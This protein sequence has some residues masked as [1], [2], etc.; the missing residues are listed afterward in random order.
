MKAWVINK[1]SEVNEN[2]PPLALSEIPIPDP[3]PGEILVKVSVCGVCHTELDEIEGRTPPPVL[4]MIPGHQ[5][6]GIVSKTG[7][8]VKKW[9]PGDRVGVAWIYS[10]CGKCNYCQNGMENLC[11]EFKATGRDLPGGYAN[12]MIADE[13]YCYRIPPQM[14]DKKAAPLFCAGAIG[15]RSVNL[16]GLKNGMNLGLSGFG[17]SAHLVMKLVRHQYP[18]TKVFV[19][20]RSKQERD[21]AI[22]LGASW[23]GDYE[24]TSPTLLNAIIDTT[25]AWNPIVKS[26]ECLAPGGR[27]VVNAIRKESYDQAILQQLRYHDHLWME[28]EIKSV[29]NVARADVSGFLDISMKA[30]IIPET[31]DYDFT[32]ANRALI[33]MKSGIIRGAKILNIA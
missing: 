16:T 6:V 20:A 25:P 7:K 4:P 26:L 14:E 2:N 9:F 12:Y 31:Q 30:G 19:F 24:N 21:F 17:A 22:E 29:A 27:L 5:V 18:D 10:S 32:D 28:K 8:G 1:I 15:Y 13:N 3:G 33:D 23:V 11:A